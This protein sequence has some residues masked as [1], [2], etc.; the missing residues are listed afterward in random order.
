V[1]RFVLRA[2]G[3]FPT[4]GP[5]GRVFVKGIG[6]LRKSGVNRS[7]WVAVAE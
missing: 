1:S 3:R 6:D 4:V 5:A 2:A 7:V